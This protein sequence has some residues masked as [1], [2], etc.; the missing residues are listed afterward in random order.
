MIQKRRQRMG[1]GGGGGGVGVVLVAELVSVTKIF[2]FLS[3]FLDS[4]L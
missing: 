1:G 2:F 3:K 4:P